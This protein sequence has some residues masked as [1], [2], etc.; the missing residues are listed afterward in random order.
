[1]HL[2]LCSYD[3]GVLQFCGS[4]VS[5][6][7]GF[8]DPTAEDAEGAVCLFGCSFVLLF[9]VLL[10]FCSAVLGSTV[11]QFNGSTVFRFFGSF[12]LLFCGA[13]LYGSTVFRFFGSFVHRRYMTNDRITAPIVLFLR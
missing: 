8:A 10:F 2:V 11:L 3:S 5:Q 4:W 9:S 13:W 6:F 12:V 7:I 1:L